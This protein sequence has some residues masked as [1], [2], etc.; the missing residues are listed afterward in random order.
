VWEGGIVFY[1]G[2]V[3]ALLATVVYT[4]GKRLPLLRAADALVPGL[5][6]GHSLGRLGCYAAGCCWGK[7]CQLAHGARFPQG[8]LAFAELE[9][10]GVVSSRA[11]LTPPLHPT[12]LYEA[13][14]EL[15]IFF[16]LLAVRRRKRFD[17]HLLVAYLAAYPVLRSIVELYRGDAARR[18]V[19]E[20]ATPR[21]NRWLGLA[22]SEPALLST[23]QLLSILMILLAGVLACWL[24]RR[25]VH[26]SV[27]SGTP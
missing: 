20:I 11:E 5:A 1:G 26:P 12:Q 4:R 13:A 17:G 19:V 24:V 27:R 9:A 25:S 14:G 3:G 7:L 23:S 18:F 6:L 15:A 21:L 16:L 10:R 2:L 8:S 22:P